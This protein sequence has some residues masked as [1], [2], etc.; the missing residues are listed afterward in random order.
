[1][2][3][4]DLPPPDLR[5]RAGRARRLVL[6]LLIGIGGSSLGYAVANTLIAPEPASL[7]RRMSR[8]TFVSWVALVSGLVSF[9]CAVVVQNGLAKR[10]SQTE[11]LPRARIH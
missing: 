7:H 11:R 10:R 2:I 4:D 1:V 3:S 6:A 8:E 5:D 9:V